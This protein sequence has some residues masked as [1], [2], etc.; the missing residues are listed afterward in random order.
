[1]SHL[2]IGNAGGAIAKDGNS[3][4]QCRVGDVGMAGHGAQ[5]ERT[6]AANVGCFGNEVEVDEVPR[7]GQTQFHQRNETLP[8]GQELSVL[9]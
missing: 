3:F 5:I 1:M 4:R 9:A 6:V 8:A 7:R 2:R